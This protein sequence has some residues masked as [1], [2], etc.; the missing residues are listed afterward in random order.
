VLNPLNPLDVNVPHIHKCVGN[1]FLLFTG[2]FIKFSFIQ[3]VTFDIFEE[4]KNKNHG[5]LNH[6]RLRNRGSK[7]VG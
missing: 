4:L 1:H 3:L 2:S 6:Y 5:K 7:G